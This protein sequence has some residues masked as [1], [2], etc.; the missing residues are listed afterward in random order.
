MIRPESDKRYE[1]DNVDKAFATLRKTFR[2][3]KTKAKAWR[4]AQLQQVIVGMNAMKD[5]MIEAVVKDLGRDPWNTELAEINGCISDATWNLSHID[6]MMADIGTETEMLN[7]PGKTVIQ[8]EP[9]GVVGIY[10]TWNYPFLLTLQPL[11]QCLVTGNC[12]LVKPSEISP[13]CSAA[14]KNFCERHMDPEAVI[15]CEG[16][17]EVAIKVNN[18]P[19]D[20]ICFTGSTPVGKIIAA[21]AA[22]NLIPCVLELGG[23][24]PMVID[25]GVDMAHAIAKTCQHKFSNSGQT[26]MA[27][28]YILV[29][30]SL[31][32]AFIAGLKAKITEVYGNEQ[33]GS[34]GQGKMVNEFHFDRMQNIIASAG[35]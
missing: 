8:Y 14:I 6:A 7:F 28:D 18:L 20:L 31:Q 23:K 26:C 11:I 32:E 35:G 15:C 33:T 1:L 19:L 9:L 34:T 29:H 27:P 5:E 4:K 17:M 10:G 2:S 24:C 21:T 22:K 30:D 25:E 12:A 16:A 13:N 3:G